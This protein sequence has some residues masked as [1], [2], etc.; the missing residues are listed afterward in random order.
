[1]GVRIIC[2][3]IK[4]LHILVETDRVIICSCRQADVNTARLS[5]E[6]CSTCSGCICSSSLRAH[7][8]SIHHMLVLKMSSCR[9]N[10]KEMTSVRT[11]SCVLCQGR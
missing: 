5:T 3:H 7:A 4:V 10:E 2:M 6:L 1:M 9:L 11:V 8:N